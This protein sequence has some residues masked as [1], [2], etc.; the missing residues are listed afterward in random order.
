MTC[1]NCQGTGKLQ[2]E[3]AQYDKSGELVKKAAPKIVNCPVCKPSC[4]MCNDGG[5]VYEPETSLNPDSRYSFAEV[6]K[7]CLCQRS[8]KDQDE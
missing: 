5:V 3:E 2:I 1:E 8:E 7:S 4:D 6:V